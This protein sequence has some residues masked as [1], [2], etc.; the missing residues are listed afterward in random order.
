MAIKATGTVK[1]NPGDGRRLIIDWTRLRCLRASGISLPIGVPFGEI[2]PGRI[3]GG[4][5]D[6]ITVHL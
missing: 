2:Q 1:E 6:L 4:K 5:D 3:H